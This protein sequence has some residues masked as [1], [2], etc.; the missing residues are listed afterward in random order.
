MPSLISA[1][2]SRTSQHTNNFSL[3]LT[4]EKL[5]VCCDVRDILSCI[6]SSHAPIQTH[7]YSATEVSQLA[8]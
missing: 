5:F 1:K 8:T 2:I 6:C 7:M 3:V 4:R